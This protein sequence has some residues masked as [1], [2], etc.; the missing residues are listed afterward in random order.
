MF[1]HC[2]PED[3]EVSMSVLHEAE[4]RA[5]VAFLRDGVAHHVSGEWERSKKLARHDL[6]TLRGQGSLSEALCP[7]PWGPARGCTQRMR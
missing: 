2:D 7:F 6:S 4:F 3:D 5:V 1:C